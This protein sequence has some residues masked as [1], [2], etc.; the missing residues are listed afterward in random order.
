MGQQ[1]LQHCHPFVMPHP[2]PDGPTDFQGGSPGDGVIEVTVTNPGGTNTTHVPCGPAQTV[3]CSG[4]TQIVIH[5]RKS[6]TGPDSI[7][8]TWG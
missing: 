1:T 3:D 7:D 2:L 5:Y 4:A 8:V 6:D